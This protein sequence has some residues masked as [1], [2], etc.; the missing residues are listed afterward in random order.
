MLFSVIVPVYNVEKYLP[1]CLNSMRGQTFRDFELILLDDGSTDKSGTLCDQFALQNKNTIVIHKK[2]EGLVLT[3]RR[4]IKEANG[5][6]IVFCDS[7]DYISEIMLEELNRI[8]NEKHPDMV[9]YGFNIVDDDH[10]V[11]EECFHTFYDGKEFNEKNR[12]ELLIKFCTTVW[13][14]SMDTK[15]TRRELFDRYADYTKYKEIKMGEDQMQVIPLIRNSRSFYYCE[16]P[17]CYYRHNLG[18]ISKN[19]TT[20]FINDYLIISNMVLAFLKEEQV[21]QTTIEAYFNR[22]LTDVY[23]YLL[24]YNREGMSRKEYKKKYEQVIQHNVYLEA[25]GHRKC[26]SMKNRC[27]SNIIN[28]KVF[29]IAYILSRSLLG[30]KLQ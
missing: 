22:Y 13:L 5:E 18:G 12:E 21:K 28:P 25:E 11:L 4:G 29:F 1:E 17:L 23:K 6:Y 26:W 2:N 15:A 30:S 3:R 10:N 14:N 9:M 8:I 20:E 24:K 7:D 19:L 16:R 27:L